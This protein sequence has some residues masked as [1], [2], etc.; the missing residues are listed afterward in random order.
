MT[1]KRGL[2]I[3][4][5]SAGIR[6]AR[7]VQTLI[8]SADHIHV[9]SR[10]F[11]SWWQE[12]RSDKEGEYL[13]I[14]FAIVA[15]PAPMHL[16]QAV[17]L[18]DEAIPMLI[19][20]P[21]TADLEEAKLLEKHL[22]QLSLTTQIGYVLRYTPGFQFF[23]ETV[24]RLG[25]TNVSRIHITS[26]SFLPDWRKDTPYKESVSAKPELGGGV[27]LELSHELDYATAIFGHIDIVSAEVSKSPGL[28]I[29][30]ESVA[31]IEAKLSNDAPVTISLDMGNR[32]LERFCEVSWIDG[33]KVR[34]NIIEGTVSQT[35]ADGEVAET[36]SLP[37]HRDNWY[38]K[39]LEYFLSVVDHLNQPVPSVKDAV[40]T[41]ELINTVW[42]HAGGK[43]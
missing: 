34:W 20:K 19:E 5:G 28:E 23:R 8:P 14:D 18:A 4:A 24:S 21:V 17:A 13:G 11:E 26:H 37:S 3:G 12:L 41:M 39:Q 38:G 40:R 35:G 42:K 36:E 31:I 7:V 6:H 30:V 16:N 27:L 9:S 33:T 22:S 32:N 25:I 10:D 29:D 15:S 43:K 2:V 1:S